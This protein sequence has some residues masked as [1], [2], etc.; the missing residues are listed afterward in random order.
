M[1]D[2]ITLTE[3]QQNAFEAF[4]KFILSP[5]DNVFVLEGYS[6]T[7]KTTLVRRI[8]EFIPKLQKMYRTVAPHA[9]NDLNIVLTATTNKA[10]EALSQIVGEPVRTIHGAIGLRVHKDYKTGQTRLVPRQG[11][12]P[13]SDSIVFVDEASY[14]D[15]SLLKYILARCQNC[16]IVF[17]GDPA[18]LLNVGCQKSPVFNDRFPTAKL[19]EVVRQAEGN[20]IIAMATSFRNTV[21]TGN[22]ESLTVDGVHIKHLPRD[23]FEDAI[24]Q[25]FNDP[26]WTHNRSKVLA[27]TNRCVINF[28]HAI[29]KCVQGTPQIHVGDYVICNRFIS[30]KKCTLKTDQLCRVTGMGPLETRQ[31]V[32]GHKVQLDNRHV[33]F[34]PNDPDQKEQAINKAQAEDN[35]AALRT[36]DEWV[37]L[38]A[39][40][41]CTINKSQGSTYDKVFIDL[42]DVARCRDGNQ[43]A[44]MLYVAVSR[45][46]ET[47]YLTGDLV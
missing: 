24:I 36:M 33:A 26:T 22:W 15:E 7:G 1:S 37:D 8:L 44:R 39:A 9:K 14:I 25:E 31:D 2:S 47:V 21:N 46:R 5:K 16:K 43:I 13:V 29:R 19:T 32:E 12:D 20:P 18:Q 17:I 40:Y 42:D 41:A 38:R 23:E 6:G 28:N 11:A 34:L 4:K 3:G 30:I 35:I 10:A 27:W 45:A